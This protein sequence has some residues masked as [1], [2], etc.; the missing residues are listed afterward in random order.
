V[1]L[2]GGGDGDAVAPNPV[3]G[4]G[5][6]GLVTGANEKPRGE[7]VFARVSSYVKKWSGGG[8][9]SGGGDHLIL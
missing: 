2:T 8:K 9:E 7:G 6:G 5:G 3:R 4:G 1:V